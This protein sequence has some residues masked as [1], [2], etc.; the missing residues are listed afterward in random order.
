MI[1]IHAE[2]LEIIR[3]IFPNDIS[4]KRLSASF[5]IFPA[6]ITIVIDMVNAQK[7]WLCLTATGTSGTIMVKNLLKPHCVVFTLFSSQDIQLFSALILPIFAHTL[8][9]IR[10]NVFAVRIT[11]F[12]MKLALMS[13]FAIR[14]PLQTGLN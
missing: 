4:Y 9:P 3:V 13:L 12:S 7:F 2:N 8:A 14:T 1:A 6:L 5:A 10:P 11:P